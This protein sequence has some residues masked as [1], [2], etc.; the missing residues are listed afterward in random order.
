MKRFLTF[1]EFTLCTIAFLSLLASFMLPH[2]FE[3]K[4][5]K[6]EQVAEMN[7]KQIISP[8]LENYAKNNNA[9]YPNS[10]FVLLHQNPPYLKQSYAGEIIQGYKYSFDLSSVGYK[11]MASPY[12]CGPK[13]TGR[14]LYIITTGGVY[15]ETDCNANGVK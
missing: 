3:M 8:A 7:L 1:F 14:K 11:I 4:I 5:E 12:K 10:E 9:T 13:G 6:N 15:N 2:L